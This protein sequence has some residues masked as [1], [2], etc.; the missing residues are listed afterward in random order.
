MFGR[1]IE[2][3]FAAH[4]RSEYPREACGLIVDG[5][6]KLVANVHDDPFHH[7]ELEWGSYATFSTHGKIQAVLHSHT[8]G[9]DFPS[10]HDME[11]QIA[12]MVPWG[13]IS[14]NSHETFPVFWFGD[15]VPIPVLSNRPFRHGVTDCYGLVRDW[16]RLN[17]GI[18][19]KNQPR[20]NEWWTGGQNLIM[21]CF[22]DGGFKEVEQANEIGDVVIGQ[23][24]SRVPNHL[25]VHV[26]NGEMIHHLTARPSR[27]EQIGI[28]RKFITGYLRYAR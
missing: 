19:L 11:Q 22:A 9:K 15:Q 24:L 23:I 20:D 5:E 12:M 4:A 21:E 25:G 13:I 10:K 26:G 3:Q 2:A 1:F 6:L 7:F 18:T 16:Y 8:N 17:R 28:W 14:L 27:I